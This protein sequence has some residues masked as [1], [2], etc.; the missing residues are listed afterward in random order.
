ML[1]H[2]DEGRDGEWEAMQ[3]ARGNATAPD[4]HPT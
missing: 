1:D 2:A 4:G 3:P